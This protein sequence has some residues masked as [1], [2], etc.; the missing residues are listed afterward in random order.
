MFQIHLWLGLL[1]VIYAVMIGVSG[2]ILVLREE[3]QEWTGLNPKV[4]PILAEGHTLIGFSGASDAV[5]AK[6]PKA[7]IGF[8]YPPRKENPG[9]Y[10][11]VANG[12]ERLSVTVHP[13][14]GEILLAE[15]PKRNWLL[16]FGQ[17]HYFL[18]MD[19]NPGFLI[20]GIA[21]ALL[22]VMSLSGLVIWWPGI[23]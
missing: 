18:L 19:R 10:V 20:N 23:R 6:Y 21:S 14:S 2:S 5:R 22:V 8:V 9:Y 12:R 4:P 16:W 13:Y 1:L 11:L 3:F 17:M 7:R 15:G